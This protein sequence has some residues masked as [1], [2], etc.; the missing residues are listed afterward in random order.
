M[1]YSTGASKSPLDIR[2]F[3]YVPTKANKKGGARW[4]KKD[5]DDQK[6]VGICTSIS[7]TMQASKVLEIDFS[8]DFQYLLQKK[9]IDGNWTEGSSIFSALKVGKKYGLLPEK[10]FKFRRYRNENYTTYIKRLQKVSDKEIEKLLKKC[11]KIKGYAKVPVD[12][13][14]MA[15]AIDESDA[16]LLTRYGI[17]SEWWTSPIEPLRYPNKFISG[18]AVNDTNYDGNSFRIAN[19]WGSGWN[20][21]GTA[22]RTMKYKPTES[23]IVYYNKVSPDI[24]KKLESRED[25]IGQIKDLL[26]KIIILLTKLN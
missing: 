2:T 6:R 15:N 25:I 1:K 7:F 14:L 22:Y 19:S 23:W 18:H 17:G 12:R 8:A 4:F 10:E 21:D 11:I 20:K 13:D 5:I 26:Q 3:A 24:E 16:G 9:F